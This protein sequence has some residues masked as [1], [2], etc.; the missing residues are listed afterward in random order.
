MIF[1][2]EIHKMSLVDIR[3]LFIQKPKFNYK[4]AGKDEDYE[5]EFKI[6]RL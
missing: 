1:T 3:K 2:F 4:E 6:G 5:S